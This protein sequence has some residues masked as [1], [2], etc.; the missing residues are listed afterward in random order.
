MV[1]KKYQSPLDSLLPRS[2]F[3]EVHA[4][5]IK[6]AAGQIYR[7]VNDVTPREI[8]LFRAM[9]ALRGLPSIATRRSSFPYGGKQPLLEQMLANGFVLL[10]GD[11]NREI[12]LGCV[13]QFWKP[14]NRPM[15][16]ADRQAFLDFDHA[17]YAKA[18][19]SFSIES[20]SQPEA[21]TIR[22]ETRIL[23]PGPASRR[24]FAAYWLVIGPGSGLIRRMWLR[25]I[26]KRAET[27]Q[28]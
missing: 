6:A 24:L 26:K 20:A 3:A 17:G 11:P 10:A 16:L 14:I 15:R 23:V 5:R 22:T 27:M 18:A 25:A 28:R 1:D 19:V 13:G 2:Q 4:V 21:V 8:A 12:V 7:A 9:F